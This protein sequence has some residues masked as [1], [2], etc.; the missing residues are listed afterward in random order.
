MVMLK[1]ILLGSAEFKENTI[2]LKNITDSVKSSIQLGN[3]SS[4]LL[5]L[6]TLD[7]ERFSNFLLFL[8]LSSNE[9]VG[10]TFDN[11]VGVITDKKFIKKAKNYF[12]DIFVEFFTQAN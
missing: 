4:A 3:V 8:R 7:V 5:N 10:K 9:S 6:H 12:D 1:S 2:N 11:I